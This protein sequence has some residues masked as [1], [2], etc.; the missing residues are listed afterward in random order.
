MLGQ[1]QQMR[2]FLD[3]RRS[4]RLATPGDLARFIFAA[5]GEQLRVQFRKVPRLRHRHPVIAPE[6]AGLAFDAA[7]F[8]R[9]VGRAELARKAPV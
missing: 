9:F 8:V 3:H 6:V 7:L 5:P 2:S 4:Y 1:R